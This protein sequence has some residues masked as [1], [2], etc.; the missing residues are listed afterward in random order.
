M[1]AELRTHLTFHVMG[2]RPA[3]TVEPVAGRELRPAMFAAYRDLTSLRYDF[4]LVLVGEG[5]GAWVRSLTEIVDAILRKIAPRGQTGEKT[6]RQLLR[7][8]Q[9]LRRRIAAGASGKLSA[10][11]DEAAAALRARSSDDVTDTYTRARAALDVDG[12]VVDCDASMPARLFTHA[13][14]ISQGKK[15]ASLSA[16]VERLSLKLSEVLVSD[17]VRSE[18][19]RAPNALAA[20][21]GTV[22]EDEF[23]FAAMSRIVTPP[24]AKGPV[25]ENR[26]RRIENTLQVLRAQPFLA[27]LR[28]HDEAAEMRALRAYMFDDCQAALKAVRAQLPAIVDLV[29]AIAIA[30]LEIEGRYVEAEHD[31]FF[32]SFDESSLGPDDLALVPNPLVCV[33]SDGRADARSDVMAVLSSGLPIKVVAQTDDILGDPLAGDGGFTLAG[34]RL[35]SM[36]V[37]LNDAYVLQ[38]AS[39]SLFALRDRLARGLVFA[40]PA[41]FSVFSG[42]SKGTAGLP[43]YLLS[44]A[45]TQSRAFPAFS[46]DPSAGA[47]LASRF[48]L[49]EN[50]QPDADWPVNDFLYENEDHQRVSLGL[51]FTFTDFVACDPR[52]SRHFAAVGRSHWNGAMV[53]AADWSLGTGVAGYDTVPYVLVVDP[54]SQLYRS[55]A[56]EPVIAASRRCADMWH[57]LQEL[58][59]VNNSHAQRLL[60]REKQAWEEQRQREIAAAAKAAPAAAPVASAAPTAAAAPAA[61]PAPAAEAE[62]EKPSD[63][64]YIETERC[65]SCNECTTINNRMFQY[66]ENKQAFIA[67]PNAGTFRQLVEAAESCQVSIIHPGKPRNA[68]EPDLAELIKRA[69]PFR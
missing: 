49:D 59:G 53:P 9:E 15:L 61:A 38:A 56:D 17:F 11:W 47:D 12:E 30:E 14:R 69:E 29:K 58:G 35:G 21:V 55:I 42:A 28:H 27:A 64:P 45:A 23:D 62:P 26:R 34:A 7:L 40:G 36:A 10:V 13:W 3:G 25:P 31:A 51:A 52:Y 18:A 41:L 65:S 44:A 37:G 19:G 20:S 67:D 8:E 39:A 22:F 32:A 33:A 4:P 1:D 46:Y 24:A 6:R 60:A 2:K 43:P 68:S 50:P 57:R 5:K 66:N 54:D 63:D 48:S 16:R